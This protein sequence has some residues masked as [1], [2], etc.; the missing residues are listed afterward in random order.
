MH[1][2]CSANVFIYLLNVCGLITLCVIQERRKEKKIT[3]SQLSEENK[4][5][6]KKLAD[7]AKR[8]SLCLFLG[9]GTSIPAGMP[10]WGGL[11]ELVNKDLGYPL[12][13]D[14]WAGLNKKHEEYKQNGDLKENESGEKQELSD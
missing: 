6:A 10:S 5:C 12:T 8:N 1:L 11:L 4:E 13:E 9:A 7:K 3:W 2:S 14:I